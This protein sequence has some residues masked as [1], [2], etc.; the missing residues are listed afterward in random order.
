MSG[1]TAIHAIYQVRSEYGLAITY[2]LLCTTL[3]QIL[4]SLHK[5]DDTCKGCLQLCWLEL[6]LC[7]QACHILVPLAAFTH[8]SHCW[9]GHILHAYAHVSVPIAL[10]A[11]RFPDASAVTDVCKKAWGQLNAFRYVYIAEQRY[12]DRSLQRIIH[13]SVH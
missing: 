10:S 6:C 7:Q 4:L 11:N 13:T 5:R 12:L 2:A 8:C 3:H 9:H 1:I